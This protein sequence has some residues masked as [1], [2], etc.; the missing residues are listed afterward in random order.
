MCGTSEIRPSWKSRIAA[1]GRLDECSYLDKDL[2]F[3]ECMVRRATAREKRWTRD[4]PAQMYS[5]FD[6]EVNSPSHDELRRV[7]AS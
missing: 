2:V 1:S 3:T 6:G 4:R 7:L 5:A